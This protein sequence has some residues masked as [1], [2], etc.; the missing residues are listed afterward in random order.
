M[1]LCHER[2]S[3]PAQNEAFLVRFTELNHEQHQGD[4][5]LL[6]LLQE[7]AAFVLVL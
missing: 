3:F 5:L 4:I 7:K 2:V 1:T 6:S